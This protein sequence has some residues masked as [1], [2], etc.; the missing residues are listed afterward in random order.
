M[1]H[2]IDLE[3]TPGERIYEIWENEPAPNR[4]PDWQKGRA[5][6]VPYDEDWE[7][8]S[9]PI[10]NG[11]IGTNLFGR[12]DTE[13]IQITDKTLHSEGGRFKGSATNFAELSLEFNHGDVRDYRRALYHPLPGRRHLGRPTRFP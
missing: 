2:K 1:T 12:T 7:A 6:G 9:I 5:D 10:G 13:R 3:W 4:G 11:H 8:W